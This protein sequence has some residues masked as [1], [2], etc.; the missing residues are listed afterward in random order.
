LNT[1]IKTARQAAGLT[2]AQL[3]ATAGLSPAAL[4][5]AEKGGPIDMEAREKIAA[6]LE[7]DVEVLW[8]QDGPRG[9]HSG[10]GV[11]ARDR[12]GSV[13]RRGRRTP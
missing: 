9:S 11:R 12:H 8:P 1:D 13:Q 10:T 7:L 4:A 5:V 2:I 3:A 6:A